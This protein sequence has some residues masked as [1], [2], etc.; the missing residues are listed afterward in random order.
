MIIM[1][2][3]L[4]KRLATVFVL[5]LCIALQC[6]AAIELYVYEGN[7]KV[8]SCK[9]QELPTIS[10]TA[11]GLH[12]ES[13]SLKLYYDETQYRQI[14]EKLRIEFKTVEEVDPVITDVKSVDAPMVVP[15]SLKFIDGKAVVVEGVDTDSRVNIY[16]MDGKQVQSN[17]ELQEHSVTIHLEH[18]PRGYYI[19]RINEKAFKIYRK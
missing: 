16:S 5:S 12:V 3:V 8:F 11:D 1:N 9:L 18:L 10:Y 6:Y 4:C 14:S 2:K 15:L 19:I 17:T 13:S 7:Q